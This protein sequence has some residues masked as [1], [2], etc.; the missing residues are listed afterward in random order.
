LGDL[1]LSSLISAKDLI[2]PEEVGGHLFLGALTN[3]EGLILP[4]EVGGIL[5]LSSLISV[6]GL[7]LPKEV[8]GN[9]DLSSL[10]SAEGLI[11]PSSWKFKLFCPNN[12][13]EQITFVNDEKWKDLC[14]Q[15][16]E[17]N[18]SKTK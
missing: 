15:R 13:E 4:E 7:T 10:T 12:L 6:E 1:D 14:K 2:L 3:A 16:R 11:V 17:K 9:L 5:N 18:N 8:G